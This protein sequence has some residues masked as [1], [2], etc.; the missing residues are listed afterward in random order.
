MV[1]L[2]SVLLLA[3]AVF[4]SFP[5]VAGQACQDL[6]VLGTPNWDRFKG[7]VRIK[8]DRKS[9]TF[10]WTARVKHD[11]SLPVP[12]D[13]A[14]QCN[15]AIN[16]P[17]LAP[18]GLPYFAFRWH[19]IKT[20]RKFKR[21]TGIDHISFDFNPCGHPPVGIFTSTYC[22]FSL[23][24]TVESNPLSYHIVVGFP[25]SPLNVVQ[26]RASLR[27]PHL[28]RHARV[29]YLHAVRSLARRTHL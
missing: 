6:S 28:P 18:D 22:T 11:E 17:I 5:E 24:F 12:D 10:K 13:P 14:N 2:P 21:V 1:H 27:F 26:Y 23:P 25:L 8:V 3:L 9:C 7:K 20:S 29:S 15:T 19:Y 16:P 4:L